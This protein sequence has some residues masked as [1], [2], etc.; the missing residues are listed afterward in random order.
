MAIAQPGLDVS[1]LALLSFGV[2][3]PGNG[4]PTSG[5]HRIYVAVLSAPELADRLPSE[6][7]ATPARYGPVLEFRRGTCVHG[8]SGVSFKRGFQA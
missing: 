6:L 7:A 2:R 3:H 8:F 5:I 1:L 4:C